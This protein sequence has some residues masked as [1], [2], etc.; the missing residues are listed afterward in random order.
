MECFD[1]NISIIIAYKSFLKQILFNLVLVMAQ[2]SACTKMP[3]AG[4]QDY[5][6]W[7]QKPGALLANRS[8]VLL[9]ATI[10]FCS[11][12]SSHR[13]PFFSQPGAYAVH[14]KS[15]AV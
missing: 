14:G 8:N 12:S 6:R 13:S 7:R 11:S 1:K 4:D 5:S 9:L 10:I 3:S 2:M 15:I